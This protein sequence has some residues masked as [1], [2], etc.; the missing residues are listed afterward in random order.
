MCHDLRDSDLESDNALEARVARSFF[1]LDRRSPRPVLPALRVLSLSHV[2]VA[3]STKSALNFEMLS[4]LTLHMCPGWNRFLN[5]IVQAKSRVALTSLEISESDGYNEET[6]IEFLYTFDTLQ[7]LFIRQH[8]PI[9]TL[10][11]W[12][13]LRQ[14]KMLKKFVHHLRTDDIGDP[15]SSNFGEEIDLN[16]LGLIDWDK[17]L[18]RDDQ[19]PLA[20]LD[21]E[22]IGFSC[23]PEVL[24]RVPNTPIAIVLT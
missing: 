18:I 8:G 4:S 23:L 3:K 10:T 16:D 17:H 9:E 1:R 20:G 14:H 21:L 11:M 13:A 7:E 22:Y 19:N 24:V 15:D 12:M 6:L 5:G 2:P